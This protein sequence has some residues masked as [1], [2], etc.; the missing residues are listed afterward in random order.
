MIQKL[1]SQSRP[2]SQVAEARGAP[3]RRL[4]PHPEPFARLDICA[5]GN[6]PTL[7][8]REAAARMKI[9]IGPDSDAE[10]RYLDALSYAERCH[11]ISLR[12][13]GCLI[14]MAPSIAHGL[15]SGPA[16]IRRGRELTTWEQSENQI[17][18]GPDSGVVAIY[19]PQIDALVMPTARAA[20]DPEHAVLH[21]LG[22]ALTLARAG[23]FELASLLPGL[24]HEIARH[25]AQAGYNS[26]FLR[27]AEIL[28]EAYAWLVVG[29]IAELPSNLVSAVQ[30]ILPMDVELFADAI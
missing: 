15:D 14:L 1:I 30:F 21:E 9:V 29:R 2:A 13:R 8:A 5:E 27:V 4:R 6:R 24:P 25:I 12:K 17:L 7:L 19:D 22:H 10:G 3:A 16:A 26:E 20:E 23:N 28:A 18:Y 11:L